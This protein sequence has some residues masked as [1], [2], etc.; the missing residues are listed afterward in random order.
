M[1]FYEKSIIYK[2]KH[3]EDYDDTN[4]YIGSTSNFKNRKYQ[5]KFACNNEKDIAH[6]RFVYQFIRDNGG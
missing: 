5:H 4:I 2:L 1:T 6:N 3:N